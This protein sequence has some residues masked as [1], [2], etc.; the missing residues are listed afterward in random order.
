M[1]RRLAGR[2][3]HRRLH[4]LQHGFSYPAWYSV[5]NLSESHPFDPR[6]HLSPD[7]APLLEKARTAAEQYNIDA[8]GEVWL[9]AQPP[10]LGIG[11]NP[12]SIYYFHRADQ[13]PSGVI[14][15]VRNTPWH[16]RELYALTVNEFESSGW[17]KTFHVSPFNPAGQSYQIKAQWPKDQFRC[18]LDLLQDDLRIMT[19]GFRLATIETPRI[20]DHIGQKAMPFI[21]LAGIYW[22]ALKLWCKGLRYQPYPAE[23][24]K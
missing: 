2:I 19:A 21:T 24:K 11:F 14:L 3:F 9:L 16:E 18:D 5:A 10:V 23:L 17:A 20:S 7:D 4:P 6:K 8:T 15:E 13:T 1:T 22:Q 12:L